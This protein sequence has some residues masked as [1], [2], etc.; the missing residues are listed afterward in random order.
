MAICASRV[1]SASGTSRPAGR[2]R[3]GARR[4]APANPERRMSSPEAAGIVLAGGRS[5]RFGRDKLAEPLDG[6]PILNHA[7]KG[8]SEVC[9]DVELVLTPGREGDDQPGFVVVVPHTVDGER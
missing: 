7:I 1:G 4:P 2:V 9:A 5:V 8:L 3:G 6:S